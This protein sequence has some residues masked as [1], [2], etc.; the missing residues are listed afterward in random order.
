MIK[1]ISEK[2]FFLKQ[3]AT[4][5]TEK[6]KLEEELKKGKKFPQYGDSEDDNAQEVEEFAGYKGVEKRIT[7]L[8]G[9]V[10]S[11]LYKLEKKQYGICEKCQNPIEKARL[12]AFPSA[13]TCVN[14]SSKR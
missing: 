10:N 5:L 2:L 3:R 14:C 11:A 7:N 6:K 13:P 8:L 4:L 1:K 12:Q 9:D